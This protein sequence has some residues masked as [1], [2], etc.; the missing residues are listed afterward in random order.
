M[1]VNVEPVHMKTGKLPRDY[2]GRSRFAKRYMGELV[3][4]DGQHYNRNERRKYYAK[5]EEP[6]PA[7]TPLHIARWAIQEF[8]K[9]N[10]WVLDPTIGAG[11]TAVEALRMGRNVAG[12]EIEF[13]EVIEANIAAN[14]PFDKKFRIV[15]GDAREIAQHISDLRF[16]LVVN[17]PPYSGDLRQHGPAVKKD[18]K[19]DNKSRFYD[20][21][22]ANLAFL[23]ENAEYW[24]AM[25]SVYA[26]CIA[27]LK[28]GG[29]FVVGVKDMMKNKKPFL[30][31][32][33]FGQLLEQRLEY[34]G[35]TVL[36][37]YPPTLHLN[38]YEKRY[39]VRPPLYQTILV[40]KKVTR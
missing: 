9:T 25:D 27:R 35:M 12:L 18:G 40:F 1:K 11:T 24:E 33:R 16:S 32:E 39:G 2:V 37:H 7:K 3:R 15:H 17:N 5:I 13:I 34:V 21:K 30:L 10:D 19:W 29:H 20:S 14:N 36:R 23:G 22:F 26:Q 4:P 6:H 8:T 38:T 28:K 31:H